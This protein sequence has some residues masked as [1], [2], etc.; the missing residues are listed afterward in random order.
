MCIRDSAPA[1]SVRALTAAAAEAA[2]PAN[3]TTHAPQPACH[4]P[5]AE[6][7]KPSIAI[8]FLS[9]PA[10]VLLASTLASRFGWSLVLRSLR[11]PTCW[12]SA[13]GFP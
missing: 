5:T 12:A 1:R 10:P 2:V 9:H 7:T 11:S 8:E 3:M 6:M 4:S 13:C